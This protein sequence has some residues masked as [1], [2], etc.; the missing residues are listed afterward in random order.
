MTASKGQTNLAVTD[1]EIRYGA[2]QAVRGVSLKV[3]ERELVAVIGNN[4]A[5]K[6]SILR[7]ITGLVRP[8]GRATRDPANPALHAQSRR[9]RDRRS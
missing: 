6:S 3:S 2:A 4:G 7:G 1:L 9:D 5:G 8:S